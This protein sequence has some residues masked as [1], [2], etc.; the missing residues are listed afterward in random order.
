MDEDE[1]RRLQNVQISQLQRNNGYLARVEIGA[2]ID[3]LKDDPRRLEPFGFRLQP[4]R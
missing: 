1:A 4:G 2:I 3:G